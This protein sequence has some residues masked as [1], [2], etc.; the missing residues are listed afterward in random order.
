[1]ILA[2]VHVPAELQPL[3]EL[4][5]V[6]EERAAL[7]RRENPSGSGDVTGHATALQTVPVCLDEAAHAGRRSFSGITRLVA[8]E[9]LEQRAAMHRGQV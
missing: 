7:V 9:Q 1:M 6:S 2:T 8:I 4:S 5:V 3:V